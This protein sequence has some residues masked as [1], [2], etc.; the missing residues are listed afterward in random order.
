MQGT[1]RGQDKAEAEKGQ[2]VLDHREQTGFYF[3]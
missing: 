3:R 2:I 1:E